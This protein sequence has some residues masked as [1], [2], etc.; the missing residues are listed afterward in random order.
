M[1]RYSIEQRTTNFGKGYEIL[2][3]GRDISNKYRGQLLDV[4]TELRMDALKTLT[5]NISQK[6]TEAIGQFIGNKI[7]TEIAEP[8]PVPDKYSKDVG[9]IINPPAQTAEILNE[10]RQAL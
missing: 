3:F 2:S 6:A 7:A 4:T 8:K 5:N 10:L 1:T 9:Q